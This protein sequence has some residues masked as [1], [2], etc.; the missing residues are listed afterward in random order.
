M[1]ERGPQGD[2]S[3]PRV[4]SRLNCSVPRW[5]G[6]ELNLPC[7]PASSIA[8]VASFTVIWTPPLRAVA[9]LG[10]ALALI[11]APTGGNQLD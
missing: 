5:A 11:P 9:S 4:R 1:V 8:T 10:T 7:R 2:A 6:G 3:G